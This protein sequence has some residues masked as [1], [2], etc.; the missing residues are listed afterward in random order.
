[1]L[2]GVAQSRT[3]ENNLN[4]SCFTEPIH[5]IGPTFVMSNLAFP[6][7]FALSMKYFQGRGQYFNNKY[8]LGD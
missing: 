1:M 5:K 7:L 6:S 4:Q 2:L 3:K 8:G